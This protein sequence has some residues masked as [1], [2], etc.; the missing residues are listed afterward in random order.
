M[1]FTK[2]KSFI[3]SSFIL[4][5]NSELAEGKKKSIFARLKQFFAHF[6]NHCI[7]SPGATAPL[8]RPPSLA[9]HCPLNSWVTFEN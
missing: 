6:G 7:L 4:N 5:Y 3:E 9:H 1:N 2:S 8:Y